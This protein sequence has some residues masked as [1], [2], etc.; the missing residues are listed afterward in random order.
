MDFR[1]NIIDFPNEICWKI[2]K[3][4]IFLTNPR[5]SRKSPRIEENR[6]KKK[7]IFD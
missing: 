2:F 6:P 7:Y 4:E 1:K 3:K 5:R